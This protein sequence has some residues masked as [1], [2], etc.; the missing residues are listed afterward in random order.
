MWLTC[1]HDGKEYLE[2]NRLT[3]LLNEGA[4]TRKKGALL[5]QCGK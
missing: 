5:Q 4:L 2:S 3:N 1:L